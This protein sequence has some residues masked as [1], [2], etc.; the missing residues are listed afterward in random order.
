MALTAG[1]WL[2]TQATDGST[3]SHMI[4]PLLRS[5]RRKQQDRPG[6]IGVGTFCAATPSSCWVSG[7]PGDWIASVVL[8]VSRTHPQQQ[9]IGPDE[10]QKELR[11]GRAQ[12][13]G[14]GPANKHNNNNN[15]NT[16]RFGRFPLCKTVHTVTW[17]T[18]QFHCGSER[19]DRIAIL[20][21]TYA[22][23]RL[24]HFCCFAVSLS[25]SRALHVSQ[26]A[27]HTSQKLR[28]EDVISQFQFATSRYWP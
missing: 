13:R 10:V 2:S 16:G 3:E 7:W 22:F 20:S 1:M 27:G 28:K 5:W 11:V 9:Q 26:Y 15:N 6:W 8:S 17:S 23:A 14:H 4:K 21:C 25:Y 18:I 24:R 19:S 12:P